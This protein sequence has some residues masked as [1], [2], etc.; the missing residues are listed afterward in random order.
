MP[1]DRRGTRR[2]VV[3]RDDELQEFALAL[4]AAARGLPSV[5]LVAGDPGIGKS[6]LVAEAAARSGSPA[7]LGRCVHVGGDAIPLA[8]LVDLVRQILRRA[9]DEPATDDATPP[10]RSA[11]SALA[12]LVSDLQTRASTS[13]PVDVFELARAAAA[14]LGASEPVLFGFEDLHWGDAASWD[15]FEYLARNLIDEHVVLVATYRPDEVARDP[16]LRRR[17]AELVRIPGVKRITLTGL[18]RTAI[19]HHARAVLGIPPPRSLVDELVRRSAGNPFFVEELVAAHVAGERIP[20][21][22]SELL[23][24]DIAELDASTRLVV[25]AIAAVGRDTDP[26]MLTEIVGLDERAIDDAV[27]AAV[28]ARLVVVDADTDA[29]RVRHP[30]IGEVA[31]AALLPSERRRLHAAIAEAL[32]STPRYALTAT[33][34]AGELAFHL[35]R[36][37]DEAGAFAASLAAADA[38]EAIAPAACRAHLERALELW[39]RHG[40]PERAEERIHRTWQLAELASAAGENRRAVELGRQAMALGTPRGRAWPQ[41]RIARY[42][43]ADGQIA[44]SAEAYALAAQLVESEPEANAAP[45]YAGLAQADLMFGRV[46]SADRWARRALASPGGD[47]AAVRSMALRVVGLV[48]VMQGR[49]AEG[50]EHCRASV[51]AAVAPHQRALAVAYLGIALQDA[52]CTEDSVRTALDGAADAQV[53]GFETSFAAFLFG[54]AANGLVRL[55]RWHEADAVLASVAGIEPMPIAALQ[56]LSST[57]TLAMRRGDIDDARAIVERLIGIPTDPMNRAVVASTSAQLHLAAREWDRAAA[58]ASDALAPSDGESRWA[59]VFT[60]Y[61]TVAEVERALDAIAR[62][63]PM[64]VADVERSVRDRLAWARALPGSVGPV[65]EAHLAFADATVT[66]L[67]KADPD[68]WAHAAEA[69]ARLG[70]PWLEATARMHEAEAAA[71]D[72]AAAR[73]ADAL[74]AAYEHATALGARPLVAQIEALSRRAR[75]SVEAVAPAELDERGVAQLGLTPREAEVL[76]LVAAGRTNREIGAELYVSEKTASVHVSNILRKLGVSSRVEAA[77]VAQ[78]LGVA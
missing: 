59:A 54:L 29:Y 76:A 43:W 5:L 52:G 39:E 71:V 24:A 34:A 16:S 67:T 33:D 4:D 37:G 55:G 38:A 69:A 61:A 56:L 66:R 30:L 26:A 36:A 50:I 28:D 47:D 46:D 51:D 13:R 77:A 42:L 1:I 17:V 2:P 62:R 70:D 6:T 74:R 32:R 35:D 15:V 58:V 72:G 60:A 11:L 75:L 9:E 20:S 45:A 7:F 53:A 18:D 12:E 68:A 21:L 19:A 25:G 23:E 3:G 57:A 49:L 22:L 41:E 8:P 78:R 14:E 63:E 73:A 65:A 27:R 44:E 48:D 31:Y 64:D 10:S 40:P